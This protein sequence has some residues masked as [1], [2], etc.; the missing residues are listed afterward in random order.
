MAVC[1]Y[2][3]VGNTIEIEADDEYGGV[4]EKKRYEAITPDS[5]D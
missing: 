2:L 4:W 5:H 3:S 1:Y